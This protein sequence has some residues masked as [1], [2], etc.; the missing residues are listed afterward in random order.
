M[1]EKNLTPSINAYT[2]RKDIL[3]ADFVIVILDEKYGSVTASGLS[4]T[5]EEYQL[6]TRNKQNVHVYIK[7]ST[8]KVEKK[9]KAFLEKIKKFGIS[10]YLYKDDQDLLSR[11]QSS[12]MSISKEIAINKL[13]NNDLDSKIM[14]K[15]AFDHDY[16]Y[17][18]GLSSIYEE[19]K[20]CAKTES[21]INTDIVSAF[22]EAR[23]MWV[24]E[25]P[26]LFNDIKMYELCLD[27]LSQTD[28]FSEKHALDYT[29]NYRACSRKYQ[30][31]II[32]EIEVQSCVCNNPGAIIDY[33]WYEKMHEN[34]DNKFEEFIKYV[35]ERKY[36]ID[37]TFAN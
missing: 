28:K 8:E 37:I 33:Q 24:V 27:A 31:P 10:Y 15:I 13:S 12:I 9:Q 3:E 4:G 35:K 30:V 21:Y 36:L 7:H 25:N 1:Y 17:A 11:I 19:F 29:Y 32:G 18:I 14:T 6:A 5:E 16:E 23:Y 34:I 26:L 2:Y 22:F 20:K